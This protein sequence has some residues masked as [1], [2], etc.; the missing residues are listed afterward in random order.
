[1]HVFL[2]TYWK[3]KREKNQVPDIEYGSM[4]RVLK[5]SSSI[6]LSAGVDTEKGI[7]THI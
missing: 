3:Q 1:M 7:P 2:E 4:G 6:N 5:C